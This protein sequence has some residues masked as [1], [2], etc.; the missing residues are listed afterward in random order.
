MLY[1]CNVHASIIQEEK[2]Y[3]TNYWS[4]SKGII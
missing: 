2:Q 4:K 3:N 1:T